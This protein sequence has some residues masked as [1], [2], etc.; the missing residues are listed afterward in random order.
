[1]LTQNLCSQHDIP[2]STDDQITFIPCVFEMNN[3]NKIVAFFL[4]RNMPFR[5]NIDYAWKGREEYN[6]MKRW[7]FGPEWN[8]KYVVSFLREYGME[9][10]LHTKI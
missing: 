9:V 10:Y 1:M 2:C 8:R 6:Q 3:N 5:G 7:A 4:L